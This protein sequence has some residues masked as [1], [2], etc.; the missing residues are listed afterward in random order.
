M[1]HDPSPSGIPVRKRASLRRVLLRLVLLL[2][3]IQIFTWTL[4]GRTSLVH[5]LPQ[6]AH[7]D[8]LYL[9]DVGEQR[10]LLAGDNLPQ[11]RFFITTRLANALG[12]KGL[13]Q[14]DASVTAFNG[15]LNVTPDAAHVML[16]SDG[17]CPDCL[18]LGYRQAW[19]TP[20]L[21]K[22]FTVY[23]KPADPGP[24]GRLSERGWPTP[25]RERVYA[26]CLVSWVKIR[27]RWVVDAAGDTT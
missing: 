4:V 26:W 10:A 13:E 17:D 3:L 16:M 18:L 20:L 11:S 24:H 22:A 5:R 12:K 8:L 1:E 7:G 19:S 15:R 27:E 14:L 6:M 9:R 21:A 2:A 25:Q 23:L